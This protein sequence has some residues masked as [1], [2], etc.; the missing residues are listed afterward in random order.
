[1]RCEVT[2]SETRKGIISREVKVPTYKHV[3]RG[4]QKKVNLGYNYDPDILQVENNTLL[5][6]PE[7][8]NPRGT[9]ASVSLDWEV[10]STFFNIHQIDPTWLNCGNKWGSYDEEE[11]SWTGCMGKVRRDFFNFIII[12][13]I[14]IINNNNQLDLQS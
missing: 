2:S 6:Y 1:M 13:I 10:F 3:C 5:P 8:R 7:E 12:P 4:E 11:G 14:I 9:A